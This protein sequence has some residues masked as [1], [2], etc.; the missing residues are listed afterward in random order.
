M[1]LLLLP[2]ILQIVTG[3]WV[4]SQN[5]VNVEPKLRHHIGIMQSQIACDVNTGLGCALPLDQLQY[6]VQQ[7]GL[8]SD[9]NIFR[10]GQSQ[11]RMRSEKHGVAKGRC[12]KRSTTATVMVNCALLHL[13][14][15]QGV[16]GCFIGSAN[17]CKIFSA[18][19]ITL[20]SI[21]GSYRA[22]FT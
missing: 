17:D 19:V 20:L 21:L 9:I 10:M 11:L 13:S 15:E 18:V 14:V 6:H 22:N 2:V 7:A 3:L 8:T 4:I 5:R 1:A 16:S 12:G